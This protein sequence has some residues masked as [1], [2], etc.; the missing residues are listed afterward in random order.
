L[1]LVHW[2]NEAKDLARSELHYVALG[3]LP[4]LIFYSWLIYRMLSQ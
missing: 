4:R 3:M 1:L 2:K